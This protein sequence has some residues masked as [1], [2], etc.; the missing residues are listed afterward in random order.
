V[1]EGATS[2]VP[3]R[4][5]ADAEVSAKLGMARSSVSTRRASTAQGIREFQRTR[6]IDATIEALL[7]RGHADLTVSAII[8]RARLSRKTFYDAFENRDACFTAVVE[9]IYTRAASSIIAAYTAEKHWLSAT[10]SALG[11]L[12]HMI[13]EEPGLARVWFLHAPAGPKESVDHR[14]HVAT[15]LA[16]TLERNATSQIRQGHS[17]HLTAEM[18]VGGATHV[19]SSRLASD[20][21][22][23]VIQLL[24][25]L[26]YMIA[27]PYLGMTRARAELQ[28]EPPQPVSHR[29]APTT[30]ADLGMRLTYRTVR[31]LGEIAAQPGACNR[32][33]AEGCGITDPGQISKLLSRLEGHGLIEN[34]SLGQ[35]IGAKNAWH[36]T[37]RG[38]EL[39]RHTTFRALRR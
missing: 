25:E 39:A 35:A 3:V 2:L 26:M 8:T 4:P 11:A 10:R 12:L 23:P 18:V 5:T 20:S 24:G 13:D 6:I 37:P 15:T 27:L 22:E 29:P 9:Q 17:G 1:P 38:Q 19:I 28:R 16:Q 21:N 30:F 31:A 33:I 32:E 34:R 7:E 14:M 36:L